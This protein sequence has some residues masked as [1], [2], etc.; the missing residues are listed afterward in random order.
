M[1]GVSVKHISDKVLPSELGSACLMHSKANLLTRGCG[2]GKC[3]INCRRTKENRQL[4]LKRPKLLVTF[5][6]GFFKATLGLRDMGCVN[7]S[8]S[9][10]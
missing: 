1:N 4:K 5:R 7:S 6:E 10:F 3:S 8:Q 2:E 9:F